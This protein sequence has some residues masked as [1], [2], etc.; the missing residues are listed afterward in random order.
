MNKRR[1]IVGALLV[2]LV[3]VVS[4]YT[5]YQFNP[6]INVNAEI[7]EIDEKTQDKFNIEDSKQ[8][9]FKNLN[10]TLIM[11]YPKKVEDIKIDMPY[12]FRK[13]LGDDIY[14]TGSGYEFN[15]AE[16]NKFTYKHEIIIN[17][18]SVD[19][20]VIKDL[21]SNGTITITW[22]LDGKKKSKTFNLGENISFSKL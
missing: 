21:L 1:V 22:K 5:Y 2:L 19:N 10:F 9:N 7:I 18:T 20:K 4:I 12:S 15:D 13:L 8:N 16:R 6:I 17:S 3:I 14:W 11:Y